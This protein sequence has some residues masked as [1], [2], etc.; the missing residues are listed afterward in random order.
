MPVSDPE[1][2]PEFPFARNIAPKSGNYQISGSLHQA[3]GVGHLIRVI[4]RSNERP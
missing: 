1:N 3:G 2:N 4:G